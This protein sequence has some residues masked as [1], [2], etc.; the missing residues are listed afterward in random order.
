MNGF[1]FNNLSNKEKMDF[2]KNNGIEVICNGKRSARMFFY[3][4]EHF[5]EIQIED[6]ILEDSSLVK[7]LTYCG[8]NQFKVIYEVPCEGCGDDE[9]YL[10][11]YIYREA[12]DKDDNFKG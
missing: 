5:D 8:N 1:E 10:D 6:E 7:E 2:I 3:Y 12:F 4:N 11:I 9:M